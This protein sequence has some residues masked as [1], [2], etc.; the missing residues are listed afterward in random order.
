MFTLGLVA[1]FGSVVRL[2]AGTRFIANDQINPMKMSSRAPFFIVAAVAVLLAG[3]SAESKR[4]RLLERAAEYQKAGD[5]ERARIEYQNVL[6]KHPEDLAANE[7]L[8]LI[9]FE[10]GSTVRALSHYSKVTS[11]TPGNLDARIKRARLLLMLGKTADAKREAMAALERSTSAAEA[12]VVLTEAVR[13]GEDFRAADQYLQKFPEKNSVSYHVAMA[14]LMN[15]GGDRAKAK[16]ALDRALALDPKSAAAHSAMGVLYAAQ[17]SPVQ[18]LAEHKLAAELSP[19]RSRLRLQHAGYLAQSGAVPESISVLTEITKQLPDCQL[20]WR[21][22]AQIAQA[23]KRYEDALRFIEKALLLD[24]ADYEALVLRA[25]TW[26]L[27]GDAPKAITEFQR[28]GQGFP[29]IGLEKHY[30]AVALLQTND[31]TGA[32]AA[33]E[34]SA[35]MYPDNYEAALLLGQLQLRAGSLEPVAAAMAGLVS[36]R[37][38]LVQPYLLLIDAM[39]GLGKLDALVDGFVKALAANPKNSLQHYMLGLTYA[40]MKKPAEARL[41]LEKALEASPNFAPAIIDLGGL[42]L[43]EGKAA[44]ALQRARSL[45]EKVPNLAAGHLLAARVHDAQGRW[46]EAEAA[47]LESIRLDPNQAVA[48]GLLLR[49]F[50]ARKA[51]PG[52]GGKLEAFLAKYPNE[53]FAVRVGAQVYVE[54]K[55]FTKARDLYEKFLATNPN[56]PLVLNNLANLYADH[57]QQPD[58]A[59]E[60]AR[61]ARALVPADPAI[62]DTLGWILYQR[63]EY[64]EALPLLE[65]SVK[66]LAANG[67]VQYHVG[68]V[69]RALGRN[70]PALAALRL[71]LAAPGEFAGKDEAKRLVAELE[72]AK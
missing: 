12:L 54:F 70:E 29:G 17:K 5:Y 71:A 63:K 34:Q 8:A 48:H 39:K 40:Q 25:R 16:L 65:E 15:F 35:G 61:K 56:F 24:A 52:I 27:Q 64:A 72:K 7:G 59:L 9:W 18:A 11:L 44:A 14:N 4:L 2:S 57:L 43:Q 45:I 26:H 21:A 50:T 53:L 22:L 1:K 62:A 46:S 19:I 38:D 47:A 6:Q 31:V 67:E 37:P 69:N 58:R 41:S 68:M 10:R 66:T 51:E 55:E 36:R 49:A 30:L 23:E 13:D 60:L 33:L 3:C 42:D 20:A 28:I 32:T